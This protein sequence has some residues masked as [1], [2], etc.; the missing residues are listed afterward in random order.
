[1]KKFSVLATT[2]LAEA[3]LFTGV[4]AHAAESEV[5]SDNASSIATDVLKK[6]GQSPENVNFQKAEDKGDYYF[7]SYGNKSGMGVGGVRVYKDGTVSLTSGI[8]GANDEGEYFEEDGKYEFSNTQ[9]S[10]SNNQFSQNTGTTM[11]KDEQTTDNSVATQNN[12]EQAQ[13]TTP[14]QSQAKVLPETGEQSN[15]GLVTVIASVLLAAGSLLAFRR[16]SKS[17]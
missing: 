15:S 1:M 9:N 12:E 5:T 14:K 2:T 7:L 11:Q 6:D 3:L 13:N 17:K 4:N 10:Q 8:R 16:V